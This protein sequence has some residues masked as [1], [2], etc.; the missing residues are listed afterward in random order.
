MLKYHKEKGAEGT[1]LVTKVKGLPAMHGR[2]QCF[3]Q[4]LCA[5]DS[6]KCDTASM[7]FLTAP[8]NVCRGYSVMDPNMQEELSMALLRCNNAIFSVMWSCRP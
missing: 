5:H 7:C 2:T 4:K 1:L 8:S 6:Y 3:R